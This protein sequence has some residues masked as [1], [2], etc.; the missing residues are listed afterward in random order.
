MSP[1]VKIAL[2]GA[3]NPGAFF[4]ESRMYIDILDELKKNG[5]RFDV[6]DIHWYKDYR[7]HPYH[8]GSN[9]VTFMEEQLPTVL[10]EYGFKDVD[11]WFSEV[12]SYSGSNV[13]GKNGMLI[14]QTETQQA[15]DLVRRY[16]HF[17]SNGVSKVFWLSMLEASGTNMAGHGP[18]DY[19][20]NMGLVYNGLGKDDSGKGEKKKSFYAYRLMTQK[21]EGAKWDR[22]EKVKIG[23][24]GIFAYKIFRKYPKRPVWVVWKDSRSRPYKESRY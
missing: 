21:L 1:G 6:L 13:M 12:G 23:N 4:N 17:L 14:S 11:V 7:T 9:L 8:S 18:D 16:I 19:F 20:N 15:K 3:S 5:S 10:L 22:I 24:S 2:A